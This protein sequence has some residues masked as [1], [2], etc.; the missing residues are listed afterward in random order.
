MLFKKFFTTLTIIIISIYFYKI[1]TNTEY[2]RFIWNQGTRLTLQRRWTNLHRA[3]KLGDEIQIKQELDQGDNINSLDK[4]GVTPLLSAIVHAKSNLLSVVRLL[5]SHGANPNICTDD[6]WCPLHA[7]AEEGYTELIKLLFN[8]QA[9]LTAQYK[10]GA[11][12][13]VIAIYNNQ[14]EAAATLINLGET[15]LV[16]TCKKDGWC[17]LHAAVEKCNKPIVELLLNNGAA[18]INKVDE[19]YFGKYNIQ[20][21]LTLNGCKQDLA[22]LVKIRLYSSSLIFKYIVN[23]TEQNQVIRNKTALDKKQEIMTE[24]VFITESNQVRRFIKSI[25]NNRSSDK[26]IVHFIFAKILLEQG[27]YGRALYNIEQALS[28]ESQISFI[29]INDVLYELKAVILLRQKAY[30]AAYKVSQ[31]LYKSAAQDPVL[32][33]RALLM[34]AWSKVGL[35]QSAEIDLKKIRKICNKSDVTKNG[36]FLIYL[37]I[38]T[39]ETSARKKDFIKAFQS[40]LDAEKHFKKINYNPNTDLYGHILERLV[41]L[42]RKCNKFAEAIHYT[43]E[44]EKIFGRF[45]NRAMRLS[46]L[47]E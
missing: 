1:A 19:V 32:Q 23:S 40:Y 14:S 10:D 21:L 43:I 5:I 28:I 34:L 44:Y 4:I 37:N 20:D 22:R 36:E 12:P 47:P 30:K 16:N 24:G 18:N 8:S 3:A 17:P 46:V 7:A 9:I 42:G 38:V 2:L 6:Q 41:I 33:A 13:L 11:T 25:K 29:Q 45:D 27:D 35:G 26:A 15:T 39:G 31:I